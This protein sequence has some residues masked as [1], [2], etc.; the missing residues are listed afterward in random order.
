MTNSPQDLA[1]SPGKVGTLDGK[2]L[3]GSSRAA[4]ILDVSETTIRN[5]IRDG[6]LPG[7]QPHG[8]GTRLL[9]PVAALN[10]FAGGV[11]FHSSTSTGPVQ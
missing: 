8:R 2:L 4:E 9:I 6:V 3:V 5:W 10:D 11:T 1:A 7:I